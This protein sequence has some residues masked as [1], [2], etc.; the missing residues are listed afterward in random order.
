MS[1]LKVLA[2]GS[3]NISGLG[4]YN[5]SNFAIQSCSFH[6]STG[7]VVTLSNVSGNVF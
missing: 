1:P 7:T 2:G 6:H 3:V 4:F 5:T